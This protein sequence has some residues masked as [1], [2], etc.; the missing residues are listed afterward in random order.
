LKDFAVLVIDNGSEF[1]NIPSFREKYSHVTFIRNQSNI[2]FAAANNQAIKLLEN[3]EWVALL[4]PDA[5]PDPDWLEKLVSA[6]NSNTDYTFFASRQFMEGNE[7]ILD[8]DGDIYHISGLAWRNNHGKFLINNEKD[9]CEIFSPCAA[10]AFYKKSALISVGGFD[11]DFFCYFEDV[12]LGFRLRLLG[13]RCLLVTNAIVHHIGSA[14]S[15]GKRSDF[16]LYYGHRNF[17]WTYVKNM[18]G[19]LLWLCMPLHL[20]LNLLSIL[21]FSLRGQ[22]CVVFRAKRDAIKYL[23]KIWSKRRSIQQS[24]TIPISR[25]WCLL[26]KRL[27]K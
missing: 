17:V 3:T 26:D 16:A 14:T 11:E 8:G 13:H 6:A 25:I 20:S 4:N 24:R 5:F 15:G 1:N 7:H 12:D 9:N 19:F 2:G 22:G 27:A 23:P 10:A 21:W 18:P